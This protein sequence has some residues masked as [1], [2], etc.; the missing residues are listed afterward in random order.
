VKEPDDLMQERSQSDETAGDPIFPA[1]PDVDRLQMELADAK[2]R[3]LRAQAELENFRKRNR[4]DT[5]EQLRYAN[6]GLMR[7][8]LPAI[9]NLRRAIVSAS[10]T[11]ESGSVVDGVQM[12]ADQLEAILSKHHCRRIDAAGAAFDPNQH[13]AAMQQPSDAVPAG[14]VAAVLQEGYLLHDRVLRP[15]QVIVSSGPASPQ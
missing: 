8:L 9:D 12:V 14:H 1:E 10:K 6:A 2:D 3:A 15:A 7:D 11:G 13:E 5:E 4:R